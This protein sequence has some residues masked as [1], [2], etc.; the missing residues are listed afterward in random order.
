MKKEK[1]KNIVLIIVVAV[2]SSTITSFATSNYLYDSVDVK[3]DNSNGVQAETVQ[4]AIDELYSCASDYSG[5]DT[6]LT[7]VEGY[8]KNN[9]TS[10]FDG[11]DLILGKT[12]TTN[13]TGLYLY[14]DN[15][16]NGGIYTRDSDHA[17]VLTSNNSK[18]LLLSGVPINLSSGNVEI[19][20]TD[21]TGLVSNSYTTPTPANGVAIVTGGYI[22]V[23]K[24][25]FVN[26]TISVDTNILPLSTDVNNPTMVLSGFP[27]GAGQ[28]L[29]TSYVNGGADRFIYNPASINSGG[30]YIY[31]SAAYPYTPTW[32]ININGVYLSS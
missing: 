14:N 24:L 4:G 21:I 3:Y 29:N 31:D 7:S 5:I 8:F 25:V 28:N 10:Y 12:N 26:M 18:P 6:R 22:K 30:L 13:N 20:G 16:L 11:N 23:G 2:I 15:V 27:S 19:M 17:F 9:P 32:A 1:I